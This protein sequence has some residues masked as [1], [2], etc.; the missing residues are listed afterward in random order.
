[1]R[2]GDSGV[3]Q[4]AIRG[5]LYVTDSSVMFITDKLKDSISYLS[6][7]DLRKQSVLEEFLDEFMVLGTDHRAGC[8]SYHIEGDESSLKKWFSDRVA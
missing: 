1:M 5:W 2:S 6:W 4:V 3:S 8:K 7:V